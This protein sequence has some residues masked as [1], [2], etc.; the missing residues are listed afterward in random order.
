MR[1]SIGRGEHIY[2]TS[3]SSAAEKEEI[4]RKYETEGLREILEG[5]KG[6]KYE[7]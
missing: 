3:K 6:Y 1:R 5:S 4:M 2:M 7:V